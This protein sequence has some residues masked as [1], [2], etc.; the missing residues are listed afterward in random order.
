VRTK[1]KYNWKYEREWTETFA[2]LLEKK[3]VDEEA[4]KLRDELL[5]WIREEIKSIVTQL[6]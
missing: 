5:Y 4:L 2:K 1:Y 3:E 6:S